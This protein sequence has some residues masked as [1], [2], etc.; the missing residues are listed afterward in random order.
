MDLSVLSKHSAMK[1]SFKPGDLV[2]TSGIYRVEHDSHRLMHEATLLAQSYFPLCR[3]C[4]TEV[5][6]ELI[7]AVTGRILPFRSATILKEFKRPILLNG[8]GRSA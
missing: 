4:G 2:P 8:G 7:R 5:R 3:E 6:F 1:Q